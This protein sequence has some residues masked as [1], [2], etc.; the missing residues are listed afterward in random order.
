MKRII[1]LSIFLIAVFAVN[2]QTTIEVIGIVKDTT[3]TTVIGGSVKLTSEKDTFSTSTNENGAFVFNRVKSANFLLT[4]TA[5]GYQTVKKRYLFDNAVT[6]RV[7]D[8]IVLKTDSRVLNEVVV[9]GVNEVTIKEDT[10]EYRADQ[11]KLQP[12]ALTEDLLKKLPGVEVDRDGNVTAQGKQI[13]RVR[14]NGK[15]FFGGDVKTATQQ[16]PADLIDKVQVIDDYGDQANITGIRDG[17]PERILNFTIRPEKNKGF[18]ARGVL[19]GGTDE[20]YQGSIYSQSF[21][22]AQQMALLANLNNTNANIFNLAGGGGG[23]RGQGRQRGGGGNGESNF[24]G[25]GGGSNGLTNVNSFGFNYRDEWSKKV[26]A[27]GS[28]SF[29]NRDNNTISSSLEERILQTGTSVNTQNNLSETGDLNHRFNFNIEYKIDSLNYLKVTPSF[30]YGDNTGF[31]T[32]NFDIL[33]ANGNRSVGSTINTSGSNTPNFG[34]EFLYNHRF[35]AKPRNLSLN[36]NFTTNSFNQEQD[37]TTLPDNTIS[38]QT[39]RYQRQIIAND[40]NND[41]VRL[42]ASYNEPITKTANLEVNYTY[43]LANISNNRI[44]SSSNQPNVEPIKNSDQSNQYQFNFTTNRFGLNYRVNQTKYNYSLGFAVQPSLLSGT[45]PSLSNKIET[46]AVNV[47]PNARFTYKFSRTR[48]INLNYFGRNN[49]PDYAQLQPVLNISNPQFP[50]RGN[51]NLNAEFTNGINFRYNNFDFKSGNTFLTNLSFNFSKDRIVENLVDGAP[52]SQVIQT[53]EYLN[54]DGYYALNGFYFFNKPLQQKKYVIGFR[55]FANYNNNISFLNN[56]QND[57]KNL[58]LSQRLNLQINPTEALEIT[59]AATYTFNKVNNS[60]NKGLNSQVNSYT[61]S[62]DSKII[63]LKTFVWGNSVDK[64]INSGFNTISQNPLIINTYL[65]KQFFKSKTG[66]LRFQAFDLLNQSTGISR[67]VTNTGYTDNRS[68][69]LAQ[70]FMLSFTMRI[71]KFAGS[72]NQMP[73]MR[74]QYRRPNRQQE[75]N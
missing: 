14:V 22:N 4:I 3:G 21:N 62:L 16:I 58:V 68:N 61:L 19:G 20:R 10:L 50:V 66:T 54:G 40:N 73:D 42:R 45:S 47:F 48:E 31:S 72:A 49:Q 57:S 41:N 46:K 53:T 56:L 5:L 18:T 30:S 35:G 2:A 63:F 29:S 67:T 37:L 55:G 26:T 43:S 74:E 70:Y 23:S 65:E 69:R 17:D 51:P 13:T 11:Y 64:T 59:P 6:K 44:V 12:N 24:G 28:Y 7:L 15:D 60:L 75:E 36:G 33:A 71:Q 38:G 8:P 39:T 32:N 1:T 25:N 52:G 27:Y 34:T 9:L